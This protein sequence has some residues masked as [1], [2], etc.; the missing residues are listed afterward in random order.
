M[1]A[2]L[3]DDLDGIDTGT[4]NLEE[5]VGSTHLLDLQD[6]REDGAE[7][8]FLFTLWSHILGG[9]F[10]LGSGQGLAVDLAV[11]RH[12]HAVHLH[13]SIRHH[14]VGKR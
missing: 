5:V 7:E 10:H 11:G 12:R 3:D 14:V 9:S 2:G 8:L 6:I 13:V 1:L 4:A